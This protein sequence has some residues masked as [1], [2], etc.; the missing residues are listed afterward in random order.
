MTLVG[1][2][3]CHEGLGALIQRVTNEF[4]SLAVNVA[5]LALASNGEYGRWRPL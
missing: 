3:S 1:Q 2:D 5:C 4:Q